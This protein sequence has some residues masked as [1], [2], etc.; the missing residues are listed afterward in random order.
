M[1][2]IYEYIDNGIFPPYN[3]VFLNRLLNVNFLVEFYLDLHV[4]IFI[5]FEKMSLKN[6]FVKNVFRVAEVKLWIS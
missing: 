4:M 2:I 5:L 6:P 3:T 1:Q